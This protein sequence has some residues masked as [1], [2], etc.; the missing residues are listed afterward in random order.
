M[1]KRSISVQK[2]C[3]EKGIYVPTVEDYKILMRLCYADAMAQSPKVIE[4]GVQIDS[5][6]EKVN[7]TE[8]G[9]TDDR[10]DSCGQDKRTVEKIIELGITDEKPERQKKERNGKMQK[11]V[12]V[13][14]MST[15]ALGRRKEGEI[16][17]IPAYRFGY[18]GGPEEG[19]E[20]YSQVEPSSKMIL[21]KEGSLDKI[22]IL[23]TKESKNDE[24][25][26]YKDEI[27]TMNAIDFYL[28]RLEITDR[29][30]V[31]II[32]LAEENLTPAI[33][34]TINT[35]RSIW[36]ESETNNKPKLWIDTQGGFRYIS[37]VINAVISLLKTS[38][39]ERIE[40]RGI[41]SLNFTNGKPV[42]PI[43]DQT[44]TY[45]IF[46]FVSGI[47]E[48]TRYGRAEQLMDY[49]ESIHEERHRKKLL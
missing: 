7:E 41:Y 3:K 36:N 13:M 38:G 22:I 17:K 20:Y 12:V 33:S 2:K 37:L 31:K 21:E 49:Y 45:Q 34:E 16:P 14:A 9:G 30:K 15:L 28:E 42:K 47:N 24:T 18:P 48:F 46:Q 43:V 23:A 39:E 25:F 27:R 6:E 44:N 40:P 29:E 19:E 5:V 4:K 35:I 11:N 1:K 26:Q 8:S 32:D 10:D